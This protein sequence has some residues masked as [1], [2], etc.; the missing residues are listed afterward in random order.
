M[1][2]FYNE[3]IKKINKN[4]MEYPQEFI[5]KCLLAYPEDKKIKIL[6]DEKSFLL[7]GELKKRD[8]GE[9]Y[10]EFNKLYDEQYRSKGKI[11]ENGLVVYSDSVLLEYKT[12]TG[13]IKV[14]EEKV[15]LVKERRHNEVLVR[16]LERNETRRR[17]GI[18][19]TKQYWGR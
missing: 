3:K 8:N 19:L 5:N 1:T 17:E 12:R 11:I 7:A 15:D 14:E 6:L 4:K 16:R 2:N 9:L 10:A 18:D 13:E